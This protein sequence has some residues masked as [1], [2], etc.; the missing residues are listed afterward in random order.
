MTTPPP[1]VVVVPKV[2]YVID[3]R[4]PGKTTRVID[5]LAQCPRSRDFQDVEDIEFDTEV[6]AIVRTVRKVQIHPKMMN[7]C[8]EIIG[9][10]LMARSDVYIPF[11]LNSAMERVLK[12]SFNTH[13]L[14]DV[15]DLL[16]CEVNVM[17]AIMCMVHETD[18]KDIW[19]VVLRDMPSRGG[20]VEIS[21]TSR[22][23]RTIN[24][25]AV[26]EMDRKGIIVGPSIG[27]VTEEGVHRNAL[28]DLV[29]Y[30]HGSE[31][32]I[33]IGRDDRYTIDMDSAVYTTYTH[34]DSPVSKT[35]TPHYRLY[36]IWGQINMG[37]VI[38]NYPV[39]FARML[40]RS[41]SGNVLENLPYPG[42]LLHLFKLK[43]ELEEFGCGLVRMIN[44]GD[45]I[46]YTS[47]SS[48]RNLVA[49]RGS[50]RI[51]NV[52]DKELYMKT[53]YTD[54]NHGRGFQ[55]NKIYDEMFN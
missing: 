34:V 30:S 4:G 15:I 23:G 22:G 45:T 2:S 10:D 50:Y 12:H 3:P 25:R 5:C 21:Y 43:P 55:W 29:S 13:G 46:T 44:S 36:N 18:I 11:L 49:S 54:G 20:S 24:L 9:K 17:M 19:R 53:P 7:H 14:N 37:D 38:L 8:R 48:L 33:V 42:D 26:S 39:I 31:E 32:L 28:I 16:Y 35:A 52:F 1:P 47:G 27:I 51:K 40:R 41:T 6:K